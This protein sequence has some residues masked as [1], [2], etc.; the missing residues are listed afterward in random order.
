MAFASTAP[1]AL[2]KIH[3][4]SHVTVNS[5]LDTFK[6]PPTETSETGGQWITIEPL[7]NNTASQLQLMLPASDEFYTDLE[8]SYI[9]INYKV[10]K[11]NGTP[12]GDDPKVYVA[13]NG[14]HSFF[15]RETYALN[16][17]DVDHNSCY[18]QTAYLRTLVD[19]TGVAKEGR[20]SG[21]GWMC[22]GSEGK[23]FEDLT[24]AQREARHNAIKGGKVVS[25][26]M[27]PFSALD[28]QP[29][30][31]P[32][33]VSLRLTFSQAEPKTYL[34][35]PDDTDAKLTITKFE[36]KVRRMCINP[37]IVRA[38]SA[39]L[40]EG[41][42]CK[43]PLRKH[44][45]RVHTIP[46]DVMSHRIV[47]D[48]DDVVPNRILL[49]MVP[50]DAYVGSYKLSPFKYSHNKLSSIELTVDG[51]SV[52]GR[53]ETD[54]PNKNYA[55]A[56]A[57]TLAALGQLTAKKGNG[58]SYEEF[59]NNKTV[60]AWCTA[61][62]LPNKDRD[63]YFHLRRKGC[64]AVVLQFAT[65]VENPISVLVCDEREDL[66]ELDLENRVKTVTGVV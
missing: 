28:R 6:V 60:F 33:G 32:P 21:E 2:G 42:T 52:G 13:E 22:D 65:K 43:F 46:K 34:I 9:H 55:H 12:L 63:Q 66:L 7:T 45:T 3:E 26:Y 57:H 30:A 15:D 29:R 11:A 5:K 27:R 64:T 48:Q 59:G 39:R 47:I 14:G 50:H 38:Q 58:I 19:E 4:D 49:A 17:Q 61:T 20:L 8:N 1:V 62:D 36:W 56:Y 40:V 35:G 51:V 25:V 37:A 16:T 18:A 24:D 41:N 44:R 31:L 10:T 54:F 23:N 53:I